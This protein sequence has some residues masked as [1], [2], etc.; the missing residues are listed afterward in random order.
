MCL[1]IG[2]SIYCLPINITEDIICGETNLVMHVYTEWCEDT[3]LHVSIHPYLMKVLFTHRMVGRHELGYGRR[4]YAHEDAQTY[5]LLHI[6][7]VSCDWYWHEGT[8]FSRMVKECRVYR[9]S[10][11][12]YRGRGYP[13]VVYLSVTKYSGNITG[14]KVHLNPPTWH[15]KTP[16]YTYFLVWIGQNDLHG[17]FN[18]SDEGMFP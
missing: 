9:V 18:A 11:F 4:R 17:E 13:R 2:V 3:G 10:V 6:K 16:I 5:D 12:A 7:S 1:Y 15:L 8:L 14:Q